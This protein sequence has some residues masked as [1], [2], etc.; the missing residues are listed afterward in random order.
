MTVVRS[1]RARAVIDLGAIEHNISTLRRLAGV[2]VMYDW[3]YFA[4]TVPCFPD[5]LIKEFIQQAKIPGVLG[6]KHASG[7]EII[8]ELG[9][10]HIVTGKPIVYTS[11][12][13]VFQIAAHEEHFG[14]QLVHELR[15]ACGGFE[16]LAAHDADT[17]TS[18][19][20]AQTNNQAG[21]ECDKTE[22]V[23]HVM[24]L[25]VVMEG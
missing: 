24:L 1:S 5:E 17:D 6:N 9:A 11:G 21:G 12:D 25:E 23:F 16:V 3:G 14:L 13:S 7:T 15:L 2:P 20:G 22:N 10:E 4:T 8:N 18:A 19:N